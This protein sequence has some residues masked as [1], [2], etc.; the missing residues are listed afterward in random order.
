[1]E[2]TLLGTGAASG[3]PNP[4]CTCSS[5]EWM[6]RNHEVRGQTSALL[7]DRLWIDCGP[8][9]PRAAERLGR[10][11]VDVRHLLFTHAHP[12]HTGAAALMWRA[13]TRRDDV[14]DVAGPPAVI[15]ECRQWVAADAPVRWHQLSAGDVIELGG[16]RVHAVPAH[17]GDASNGPALLYDIKGPEGARLLWATDTASLVDDAVDA[18][19]EAKFDV[20]CLEQTNG[21]DLDA[22][23]DHLDLV[24]WPRQVAALREVGAITAATKL[25]AIHLGHGNPPPPQLRQRMAGWAAH[26]PDDGEV[27]AVRRQE[28]TPS[29]TAPRRV[30]VVGGARSGKSRWAESMLADRTDV[31]YVATALERPDDLEWQA[32]VAAHRDRRPSTWT[33]VETLDVAKAIAAHDLV[34]V[35]CASLWLGALLD[36]PDLDERLDELV[37]AVSTARGTVVI[38]SNEVGSGVVPPTPAGRQFRD[39][40]GVLNARLARA[41][42]EVWQLTAGIPQRLV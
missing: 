34:L 26:V 17:H 7:D 10:R 36:E 4:W 8:E 1:M 24:T 3:W 40:L 41:C 38:V 37:A 30:L 35:D 33:T 23:T 18:L 15:D 21:D 32:R 29:S 27:I 11:V 19:T 13:W 28:A 20:V 12:D 9:A 5:C 6:R 42:D 14:I 16:Y 25:V 39:V 2:L 31:T 22:N